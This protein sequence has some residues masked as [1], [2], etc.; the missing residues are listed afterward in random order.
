MACRVT[1]AGNETGLCGPFLR[2]ETMGIKR[3]TV[4]SHR[5]VAAINLALARR[6][7]TTALAYQIGVPVWMPW[8]TDRS[9]ADKAKTTADAEAKLKAI[10]AELQRYSGLE[11]QR[12]KEGIIGDAATIGWWTFRPA[13]IGG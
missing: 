6:V 12:V 9:P 7:S 5:E 11:L 2:R 1:P 10:E 4:C 3:C 8:A 13:K